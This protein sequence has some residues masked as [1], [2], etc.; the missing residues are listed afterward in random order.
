MPTLAKKI[1]VTFFPLDNAPEMLCSNLVNVRNSFLG[2]PIRR[3]AAPKPLP[4]P[5][6]RGYPCPPPYLS[7]VSQRAGC[8]MAFSWGSRQRLT[9]VNCSVAR[10]PHLGRPMLLFITPRPSANLP[11]IA[12]I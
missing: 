9:A 3:W 10:R 4:S 6:I 12:S 7:H 1:F 5:P 11:I 2:T 8:C